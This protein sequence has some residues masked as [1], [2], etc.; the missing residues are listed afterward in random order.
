M[1]FWCLAQVAQELTKLG[2]RL[3]KDP[4][5][6]LVV[7]EIVH[8]RRHKTCSLL[9]VCQKAVTGQIFMLKEFLVG[10]EEAIKAAQTSAIDQRR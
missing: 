5:C 8:R 4:R 10:V 1:I 6:K 3:V 9:C 2:G 7:G